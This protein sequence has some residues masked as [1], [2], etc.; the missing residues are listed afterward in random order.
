[1][2]ERGEHLRFAL[3]PGES[4]GVAGEGVRQDLDRDVAIQLGIA[5]AI[6]LAHAAGPHG[7][8][9][10]VRAEADARGWGRH[11]CSVASQFTNTVIGG[12]SAANRRLL[13]DEK[14]LAVRRGLVARRSRTVT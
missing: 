1:M 5:R 2:V 13:H 12:T 10:L 11:F 7:G 8:E 14:P 3:E 4:F 6:H 9:D